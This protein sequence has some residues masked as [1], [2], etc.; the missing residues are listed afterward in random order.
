ME[1]YKQLSER[2]IEVARREYSDGVELAA[3]FGPDQDVSVDV[4]DETVIVVTGEETYDINVEGSVQAFIKN[5][6]LTIEVD[7]EVVA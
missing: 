6:V 5:G 7:Q 4:V 2:G 1:A 3:D